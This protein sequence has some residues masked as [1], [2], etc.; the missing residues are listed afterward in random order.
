MGK[1]RSEYAALPRCPDKTR[2][3]NT[4][5]AYRQKES[6]ARTGLSE[7]MIAARASELRPNQSLLT[8][9]V[10]APSRA[11]FIGGMIG[12]NSEEVPSLRGSVF[13]CQSASEVLLAKVPS[14]G[15]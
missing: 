13:R 1:E 5:R 15:F 2:R 11:F 8:Q 4:F 9:L 12:R 10:P 7:S 14:E 3:A 6:P